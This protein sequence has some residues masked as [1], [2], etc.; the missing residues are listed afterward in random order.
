M[1]L[2]WR[3]LVLMM[4]VLGSLAPAAGVLAQGGEHYIVVVKDEQRLY[5][6]QGD[7]QSPKATDVID[8]FP[9]NTGGIWLQFG[10][11]TPSGFF[12]VASKSNNPV[13]GGY[14]YAGNGDVVLTP[15]FM[16][17]NIPNRGGIGIHTYEG[18]NLDLGRFGVPGGQTTHGC[19]SGAPE[20]IIPLYKN[21][22]EPGRTRVW[23]VDHASEAF[24]DVPAVPAPEI[25]E[26][27]GQAWKVMK[28]PTKEQF[29]SV[30]MVRPDLG[31]AISG[32]AYVE[33]TEYK[34]NT[35][36]YRYDGKAWKL[37]TTLPY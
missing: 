22:V 35:H 25:T 15:Y 6:A 32:D 1:R 30:D 14:S 27:N 29:L 9:V 24:K 4:L 37:E 23:V 10:L 20:D 5:L 17:L 34:W 2:F 33:G 8:K 28:S 36:V 12:T 16:R 13:Q 18:R 21:Y 31:W 3:G 19:I 7:P 26:V 11:E